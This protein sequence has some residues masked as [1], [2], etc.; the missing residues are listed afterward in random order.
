MKTVY[1]ITAL[2]F[3]ALILVSLWHGLSDMQA[4]KNATSDSVTIGLGK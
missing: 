1:A 2:L 4:A 3:V